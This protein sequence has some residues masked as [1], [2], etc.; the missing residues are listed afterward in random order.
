MFVKNARFVVT[1][2]ADIINPVMK[3]TETIK[4][5]SLLL[6]VIALKL[7]LVL[8]RYNFQQFRD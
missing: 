1:R 3:N 4:F 6:A 2:R 8:N 7:L 5:K